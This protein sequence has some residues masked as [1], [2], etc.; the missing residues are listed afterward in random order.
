MDLAIGA[1]ATFVMMTLLTRDGHSKF[2][3]ACTYPLTGVECVSR[4]YTD[5]G[6]F[7]I[8]A[9]R[10]RLRQTFGLPP[11]DLEALLPFQMDH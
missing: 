7:S 2:V 5:L 10:V 9:G 1:K 4:L 8:E 3:E 11:R 6:V